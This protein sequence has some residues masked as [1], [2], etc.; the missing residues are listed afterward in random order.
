M[1]ADLDLA[2][3]RTLVELRATGS[4]TAAAVALGYTTGA[5]SQQ[6]AALRRSVR[7]ELLVQVGRGVQLT[8]A[9][10]LLA[11]RAEGLLAMAR[12]TQQALASL[13]GGARARVLIGV[14]G[15]AAAL[16]PPA[17]IRVRERHPGVHLRSVE[18][19][20]DDAAAA[21]AAGRVD[22]AFGVDYPQAPIPRAAEVELLALGTER[23]SIA[24]PVGQVVPEE[25]CSLTDFAGEQWILPPEHTSYGRALRAACRRLDFEP[26]V[27]HIVTDT[28]STLSL[29]AAGLGVAPVTPFMLALRREG[30]ATVR[31][32]DVVERTLVL[33]RRRAPAPQ[34]GVRAVVDAIRASTTPRPVG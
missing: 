16:L 10:H 2:K 1:D 15:T 5:V 4:M 19:D 3:L 6:M 25:P 21:V 7:A 11:D 33:A 28:A 23:F 17:L 34:P 30:L 26:R 13:S 32:T 31:L 24:V 22:L 29:V 14:F 12:E 27:D 9:G 8:D 18:V 20:V